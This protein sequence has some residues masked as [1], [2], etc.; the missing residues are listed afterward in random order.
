MHHIFVCSTC[1][2][3]DF[4]RPSPVLHPFPS[5][6][7]SFL[8]IAISFR[9]PTIGFP[10]ISHV[11][12]INLVYSIVSLAF[13]VTT[14]SFRNSAA[15]NYNAVVNYLKPLIDHHGTNLV[16]WVRN[17]VHD[18]VYVRAHKGRPRVT[19]LCVVP[20]NTHHITCTHFCALLRLWAASGLNISR[21]PPGCITN[22]RFVVR[23]TAIPVDIIFWTKLKYISV[24]SSI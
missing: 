24:S 17:L 18:W 22:H 1:R 6:F 19:A 13:W 12:C 21:I 5:P 4:I 16:D 15:L 9:R 3:C 10:R 20:P 14:R 11:P 7:V 23:R 8:V 2:S